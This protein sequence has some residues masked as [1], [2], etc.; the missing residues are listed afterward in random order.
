MKTT[1]TNA[2]N[3]AATHTPTPWRA[4]NLNPYIYGAN[5]E[6]IAS[7]FQNPKDRKFIV[8]AVNERDGLVA[9]VAELES[10]LLTCANAITCARQFGDKMGHGDAA[11]L[12]MCEAGARRLLAKGVQS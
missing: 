12:E 5:G 9:R 4:S 10:A 2:T 8:A 11:H 6:Y 3:E 1:A 7:D